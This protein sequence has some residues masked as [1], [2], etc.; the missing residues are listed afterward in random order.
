MVYLLNCHWKELDHVSW[1]RTPT[2]FLQEQTKRP[3]KL[4]DTLMEP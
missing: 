4:I 2:S 3:R 1:I